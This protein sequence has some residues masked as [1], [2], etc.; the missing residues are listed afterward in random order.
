MITTEVP[1]LGGGG[2]DVWL[3]TDGIYL[4]KRLPCYVAVLSITNARSVYFHIASL[5]DLQH[6][7]SY[8]KR[9]CAMDPRSVNQGLQG[10][11]DTMAPP[12]LV[13]ESVCTE[14]SVKCKETTIMN[15]KL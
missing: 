11:Q 13:W 4:S 2:G 1:D 9:P 6:G 15:S 5:V 12:F 8:R 3:P 14:F 7:D 10:L